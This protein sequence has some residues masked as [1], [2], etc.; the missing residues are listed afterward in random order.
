MQLKYQR[1]SEVFRKSSSTPQSK[2]S[3]ISV[4]LLLVSRYVE[5]GK[6]G[7]CTN[8]ELKYFKHR[9]YLQTVVQYTSLLL[10]S[11]SKRG[12]LFEVKIK[13]RRH[14]KIILSTSGNG[15]IL[16]GKME[17]TQFLEE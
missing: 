17:E 16:Y 10:M 6:E 14:S 8:S 4:I 5:K 2:H 3:L 11:S 15:E 12:C 13:T 9:L 7:L 1:K